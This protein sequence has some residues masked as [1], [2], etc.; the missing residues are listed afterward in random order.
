[1]ITSRAISKFLKDITQP[2]SGHW[3]SQRDEEVQITA[4]LFILGL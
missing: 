4:R 1:M 2:A 3:T